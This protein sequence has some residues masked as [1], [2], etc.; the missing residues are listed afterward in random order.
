M[1][2]AV[3][4]SQVVVD[5]Q[6]VQQYAD[7]GHWGYILDYRKDHMGTDPDP[8]VL[9]S[10]AVRADLRHSNCFSRIARGVIDVFK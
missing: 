2:I 7:R 6:A 9:D 8:R 10:L 1:P 5:P 4:E 3:K